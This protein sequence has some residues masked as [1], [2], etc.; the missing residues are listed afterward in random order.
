M[1]GRS[2]WITNI[3]G[4]I[5]YT[6]NKQQFCAYCTALEFKCYSLYYFCWR[7]LLV[8]WFSYNSLS[9][10]LTFVSLWVLA[11]L[12]RVAAQVSRELLC[13]ES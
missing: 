2:C 4:F 6:P 13:N 8:A 11:P 12:S 10:G 1:T 9:S 7:A 5:R 3:N